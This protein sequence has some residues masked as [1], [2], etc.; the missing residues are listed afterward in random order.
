MVH[1]VAKLSHMSS[2][3]WAG[4]AEQGCDPH[5]NHRERWG[6]GVTP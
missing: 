1:S 5:K 3:T 2:G 4:V 6:E